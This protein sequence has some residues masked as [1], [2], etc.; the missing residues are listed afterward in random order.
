M[1]V[2]A[3]IAV[4]PECRVVP[5]AGNHEWF[6]DLADYDPNAAPGSRKYT[7]LNQLVA[8]VRAEHLAAQ[9]LPGGA[10]VAAAAGT[11]SGAAAASGG[12]AAGT[13]PGAPGAAAA[14]AEA[15]PWA[16]GAAAAAASQGAAGSMAGGEGLD[17]LLR[18]PTLQELSGPVL[19]TRP[20]GFAG[21]MQQLVEGR[22]DKMSV[23]LASMAMFG[24]FAE[25]PICTNV[26]GLP[27]MGLGRVGWGWEGGGFGAAWALCRKTFSAA[28]GRASCLAAAARCDDRSVAQGASW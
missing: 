14:A 7:L 20:E 17:R 21:Q 26:N 1:L 22:Y 6:P 2:M 13:A 27:G 9:S 18:I 28:A 10:G 8:A 25:L 23:E 12:T 24:L 5:M 19:G 3:L 15:D 11:G 16:A 4:Y